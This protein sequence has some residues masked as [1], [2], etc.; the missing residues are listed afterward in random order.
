MTEPPVPAGRDRSRERLVRVAV[1]ETPL[2]AQVIQDSLR[3]AG[4]PSV[5]RNR[6][7]AAITLGGL[8]GLLFSVDIFVLE[9]DADA[10][11]ALL[12]G[13]PP[14]ALSPPALIRRPR[15]KRR[16]RGGT[17]RNAE[18]RGWKSMSGEG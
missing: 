1:A 3:D 7:G 14:E 9:G 13:P 11:N 4:I 2:T 15:R 10:A 8:G 12:G 6:D 5:A 16:E 17:R 18:E